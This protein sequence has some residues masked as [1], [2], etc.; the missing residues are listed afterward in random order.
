VQRIRE[1]GL[2]ANGDV[3]TS[4]AAGLKRRT[5]KIRPTAAV[6]LKDSLFLRGAQLDRRHFKP[7]ARAGKLRQDGA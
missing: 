1:S 7:L 4:A 2:E 6:E 5:R 3:S